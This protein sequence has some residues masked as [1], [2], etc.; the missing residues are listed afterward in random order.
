M[1]KIMRLSGKGEKKV[2]VE[3]GIHTMKS[4]V[5]SYDRHLLNYYSKT[6]GIKHSRIVGNS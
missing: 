3:I 4:A 6:I 5:S 1:V 2:K